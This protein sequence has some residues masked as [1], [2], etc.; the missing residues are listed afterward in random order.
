MIARNDLERLSRKVVKRPPKPLGYPTICSKI[1]PRSRPYC[2]QNRTSSQHELTF[3]T[4]WTWNTKKLGNEYEKSMSKPCT[5]KVRLPRLHMTWSRGKEWQTI[6]RLLEYSY[7]RFSSVQ[8]SL[9][10]CDQ[11]EK[12]EGIR[13]YNLILCSG[14]KQGLREWHSYKM[15]SIGADYPSPIVASTM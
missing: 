6:E 11:L 10:C 12:S 15:L 5:S 14:V 4:C 8:R 9:H 2:Y 3:N 7:W 1:R 13:C